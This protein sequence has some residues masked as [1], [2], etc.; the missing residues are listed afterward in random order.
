LNILEAI[1]DPQVFG[2]AFRDKQTWGAWR[3]FLAALFGLPLTPEQLDIYWECTQR[4]DPPSERATEAWLVIGRR[5]GKSFML[6]LIAVYLAAFRDWRPYLGI[7]ESAT[8]MV[9]ATDRRQARVIMRYVKGLLQLVPM[10]RQLIVA[11]QQEAVVLSNRVVIEVHSAS[12]RTTRGYS[13]CAALL[14]ELAFWRSDEDSSNPD[15]EIINAI[16][17]AM[18]TIPGA[19]LLCASSPYAR[20]GALFEAY[21]RY[22]GK[23]G[24]TLVWR[25]PTRTM[26]PS[27][28]Q[29]FIDA[30]FE[31]DSVSA[32]AEFGAEF[33]TD[34]E[35]FIA[36]EALEACVECGV[37]ERGYARGTRYTGFVDVSGGGADSF[38]LGIAH[39]EGE[40]AVLDA[41]REVRPPLSPEGV[42]SEFSD[43]LKLYGVT[44]IIG[45]RYAGQFPIEQ[46]R[47]HGITYE[48]SRD[49][50]GTIYLNLLP[51]LNSGKV[52]L[53]NN[54]RLIHQLLGLERNTARGGRDNIDHGRGGHDDLANA[55]AGALV[56]TTARTAGVRISTHLG[57]SLLSENEPLSR[58]HSRVF[59]QRP[60]GSCFRIS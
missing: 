1:D 18:A 19:L 34:I 23:D 7:G 11:E 54:K 8:V 31:K 55:A 56:L 27:V 2:P 4:A 51:M 37:R 35:S 12:F 36:R 26:N 49:P 14:D 20:K 50:K 44:R 3:I 60:D 43:T 28:P 46:F 59:V 57:P 32:E 52:R 9:I 15:Y 48:H 53:L 13:I 5:G 10:L 33:R 47:K 41:L 30:E 39:K 22:F 21:D 16:R 29:A 40:V 24:S 17:P 6:A 38:A 25:A 45:D 42:I 58:Q